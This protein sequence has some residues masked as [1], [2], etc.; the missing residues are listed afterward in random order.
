MNKEI[1]FKEEGRERLK[2]GVDALAEAV[3][4]TL[5]P[6]GRNVVIQRGFG[7]TIITKDGVTVAEHIE[8]DDQIANLGAGLI[9]E[10]AARTAKI[11]GDGT[12][13]ATVLTQALISEGLKNMAAGVSPVNLKKG[14]EHACEQVLKFIEE[15]SIKI[16]GDLD[17]IKAIATISS[18][19]DESLGELIAN[20]V[21]LVTT[22]GIVTV[23]GSPTSSTY[24]EEVS[25][26]QFSKG[27]IS[28]YF[29]TDEKKQIAEYDDPIILIYQNRFKT[30][31]EAAPAL[32]RARK[33][34]R[35]L[36]IIA[37][38]MDAQTIQ[39]LL[40]NK[41][42]VDFK[43]V[44]VKTPGHGDHQRDILED[45]AV[46]TGGVV[47]GNE[48]GEKL[49]NANMVHFGKASK[50]VV[51]KDTTTIT[52]GQGDPDK[53][54]ARV[55]L[56]REQIADESKSDFDRDLL[57]TRLAKL[58]GGVAIIHV[59]G[60]TELEANERRYRVEDAVHAT[61]AAIAEGYLPGGGTSL[62]YASY[63]DLGKGIT[64]PEVLLGI[65]LF[66]RALRS[67]IRTIVENAGVS[68]EV[69]IE[70]ISHYG[71]L[72]G[73]ITFG[74]DAVTGMYGDLVECGIIDPAKVVRVGVE[75]A[76]SIAG[77]ILTTECVIGFKESPNHFPQMGMGGPGMFG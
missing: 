5:G 71:N 6:K 52:G 23:E 77:L 68:A 26:M 11:A 63:L 32:E 74:Y 51:D 57:K 37:Q 67:P 60:P 75:N 48:K 55:E 31:Q 12:T 39:A 61:K 41:L 27:F 50:V 58:T 22:D 18:N 19:N 4:V 38:D 9:K 24:L 69:V 1:S 73:G 62:L 43:V 25:G 64:D 10:V 40:V 20:A 65:E 13:T 35:P 72:D 14:I 54:K 15:K 34:G 42:R 21:S 3:K 56:I 33:S 59:G 46:L 49:E 28:P 29:V 36:L 53:I 66:K 45:I 17:K 7:N 76:A 70:Y 30:I 8:L 47:L 2:K 44:A 16:E